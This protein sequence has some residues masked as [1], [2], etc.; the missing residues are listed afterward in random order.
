MYLKQA[1]R[2]DNKKAVFRHDKLHTPHGIY[3]FNL[4]TEAIDKVVD[5]AG[6]PDGEKSKP[7]SNKPGQ[8]RH[9]NWS[10]AKHPS[11]PDSAAADVTGLM[12][13][14]SGHGRAEHSDQQRDR[15]YA[16]A[17]AVRG[18]QRHS[19]RLRGL[20]RARIGGSPDAVRVGG[21]SLSSMDSDQA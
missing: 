1:Y 6:R 8:P 13:S 15:D 11:A 2:D 4:R 5:F 3:E 19:P 21:A 18:Q 16:R 20:G 9:G 12:A 7:P 10:K 17:T 14:T